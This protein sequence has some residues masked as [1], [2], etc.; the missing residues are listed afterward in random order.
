MISGDLLNSHSLGLCSFLA[1]ILSGS[2]SWNSGACSGGEVHE[3]L[4][5]GGFW[6]AKFLS[7]FPHGKTGFKC[8]P[9]TSRFSIGC[10]NRKSESQ[11]FQIATI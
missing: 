1:C 3:W 8:S 4:K 5:C 7:F 2:N 10:P 6:V 9:K 11:Q